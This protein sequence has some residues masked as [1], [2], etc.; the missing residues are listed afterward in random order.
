MYDH[1]N[2]GHIDWSLVDNSKN[3]KPKLP[4]V[5]II[6]TSNINKIDTKKKRNKTIKPTSYNIDEADNINLMNLSRIIT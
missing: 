3:R 6:D 4:Q 2:K 1:D 5:L